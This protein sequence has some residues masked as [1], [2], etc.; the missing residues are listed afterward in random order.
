MDISRN[1]PSKKRAWSGGQKNIIYH[2]WPYQ[3]AQLAVNSI[4]S[5]LLLMLVLILVYVELILIMLLIWLP[6]VDI[7]ADHDFVTDIYFYLL[8]NYS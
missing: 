6:V 8:L 5:F 7:D 1:G 2:G 3:Q 4:S